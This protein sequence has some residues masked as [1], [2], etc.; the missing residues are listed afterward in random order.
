MKKTRL[1]LTA[2]IFATALTPASLV[3]LAVVAAPS[4]SPAS[5]AN[6]GTNSIAV[7]NFSV[8]YPDGWSTLQSGRLTIILNVPAN[9]QG[10][11]GNQ[12]VYTPQVSIST[13]E[14]LDSADALKQLDELA[15]GAGPS[16]VRL[17]VGGWP[18]VQWRKTVPWP[19]AQRQ[20]P[21]PGSALLINTVI[22]A[23]SQ[24]IRLYG[25]LPS[26]APSAIADTIVAIETSV[27]FSSGS[28]GPRGTPVSY[29]VNRSSRLARTLIQ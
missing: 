28:I 8:S 3:L 16:L 24:L 9:Q 23:G 2:R 20:A 4:V 6:A 26:D 22:A 14:R 10:A 29:L 11:L 13:E 21:A 15:A 27:S 7:G 12:F 17:T 18:A 1:A 19:H 5:A 25:S